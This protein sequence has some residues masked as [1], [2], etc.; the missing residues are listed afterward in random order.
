MIPGFLSV[1]AEAPHGIIIILSLDHG[2]GWVWLPGSDDPV[3]AQ[4]MSVIGVPVRV[5]EAEAGT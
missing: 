4:R 3:L 5:F 2:S 1:N